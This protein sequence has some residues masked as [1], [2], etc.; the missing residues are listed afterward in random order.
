MGTVKD[1]SRRKMKELC[2]RLTETDMETVRR[3]CRIAGYGSV[4]RF[5]RA[6]LTYETPRQAASTAD[7][8]AAPA[9]SIPEW[10]REE[11]G[12]LSRQIRGVAANYNQAV[13]V[14]N[15][16]VKSVEG[17]DTQRLIIRRAA[18]LDTLT[19]ELVDTLQEMKRAVEIAARE[20]G[21]K[22]PD[23]AASP[24]TEQGGQDEAAI[25]NNS[26]K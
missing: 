23:W 9:G 19:R 8:E 5:V 20:A 3:N 10:L 24:Q 22:E 4:S 25:Q 12:K 6:R 26:D 21:M 1:E 17:R 11:M 13:S 14:M 15:T 7:R 16:L 18:R 2:V